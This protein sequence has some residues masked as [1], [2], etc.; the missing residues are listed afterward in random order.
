MANPLDKKSLDIIFGEARTH[1]AWLN[2]P[3]EDALLHRIFDL[4]RLGPT[5]ANTSPMR[6][7]FVKSDAAK[8]R[9][10]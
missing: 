4:A 5:S 7:V 1:T 8:Q 10:Q 3:V 6:V 9:L 2:K